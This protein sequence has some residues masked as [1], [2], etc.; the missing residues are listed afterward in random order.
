M[1]NIVKLDGLERQRGL[2]QLKQSRSRMPSVL[3][4]RITWAS[5]IR[6]FIENL[7]VLPAIVNAQ[8]KRTHKQVSSI[9]YG[10]DGNGSS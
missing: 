6:L 1:K 8:T 10:P 3:S 4:F 2:S 5:A 7:R 9:K